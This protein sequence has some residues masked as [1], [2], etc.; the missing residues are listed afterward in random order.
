M[1]NRE[2]RQL[3]DVELLGHSEIVGKVVAIRER[4]ILFSAPMVRAILDG[5]KT[6]TRRVIKPQ[7]PAG[8]SLRQPV[9]CPYGRPG[10]KLW[11]RE[12]F[13]YCTKSGGH[14][15]YK[16]DGEGFS[17]CHVEGGKWKPSIF[18][19][20]VASRITLNVLDIRV[21][22]V[23]DITGADVLSEGVDNGKSNPTMGVRWEN[24]QRMAFS[25]LWDS[26]NAGRGFS[27]ESNPWI[28]AVKFDLAS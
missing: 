24:M 1:E 10:D 14:Y 15:L 20:R 17:T 8:S 21:E 9:K 13:G 12:T 26:I 11:V 3:V 18:M 22:R 28:W 19:P 25:D 2:F 27:W 23:Q 4:P 7:P 5:R 6:Q 16:A